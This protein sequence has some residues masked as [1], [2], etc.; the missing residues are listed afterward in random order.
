MV[1]TEKLSLALASTLERWATMQ[2]EKFESA[3]ESKSTPATEPL[4]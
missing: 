4:V 3:R 1:G 2:V